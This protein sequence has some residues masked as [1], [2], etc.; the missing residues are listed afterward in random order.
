MKIAL[1]QQTTLRALRVGQMIGLRAHCPRA[2]MMHWTSPEQ[3]SPALDTRAVSDLCSCRA[4]VCSGSGPETQNGLDRADRPASG[5]NLELILEKSS[6]LSTRQRECKM[7]EV[8]SE[9]R[10]HLLLRSNLATTTS[11]NCSNATTCLRKRTTV[12]DKH[13]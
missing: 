11:A 10:A 9:S 5:P 13:L 4:T 3:V 7:L 12:R 2:V 1:L 6:L 8:S